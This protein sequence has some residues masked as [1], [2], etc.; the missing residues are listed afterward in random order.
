MFEPLPVSAVT[1]SVDLAG[2]DDATGL[3]LVALI[4]GS[5]AQPAQPEVTSS[6]THWCPGMFHQPN[7]G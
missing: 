6:S 2:S 4:T 5:P 3:S 7:P 1:V